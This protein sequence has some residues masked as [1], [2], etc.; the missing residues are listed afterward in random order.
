VAAIRNLFT[1]SGGSLGET[2]S[3]AWMFTH[4]GILRVAAG[5]RDPEEIALEL[6]DLL[7]VGTDGDVSV[8]GASVQVSLAPSLFEEARRRLEAARY[9]VESAEVTTDPSTS[10]TLDASEARQVLRL[11]DSLEEHDDVQQVYAN[12]EIPDEV[13]ESVSS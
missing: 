1:R 3:V 13:L 12:A 8:D 4:Q 7:D 5:S 2:N 10:V 9:T 6:L 11:L